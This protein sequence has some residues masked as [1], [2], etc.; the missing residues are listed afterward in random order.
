MH[1]LEDSGD[2]KDYID[3]HYG[4]DSESRRR[5]LYEHIRFMHGIK[6]VNIVRKSRVAGSNDIPFERH[7]AELFF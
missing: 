6:G 3:E 2:L 7:D 5:T 4:V 1:I